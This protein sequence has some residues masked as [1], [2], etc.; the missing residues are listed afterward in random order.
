MGGLRELLMASIRPE[1]VSGPN[2]LGLF[3]FWFLFSPE[4]GL[5]VCDSL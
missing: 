2:C 1:T 4:K 5:F 3:V